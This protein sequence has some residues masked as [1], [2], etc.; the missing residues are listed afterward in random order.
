MVKDAPALGAI[1]WR[2]PVNPMVPAALSL[3][4]RIRNTDYRYAD[5]ILAATDG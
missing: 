2:L 4:D 3:D 5:A 1:D